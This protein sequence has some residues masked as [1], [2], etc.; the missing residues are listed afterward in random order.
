MALI[1]F[2]CACA[3]VAS[4][5][6]RACSA[7][8]SVCFV[9]ASV[10]TRVRGRSLCC[11]AGPRLLRIVQRLLCGSVG[12]DEGS[13]PLLRRLRGRQL[14]LGLGKFSLGHAHGEL[15][16]RGGDPADRPSLIEG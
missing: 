15:E 11:G 5:P 2:A 10:V 13:L 12:C 4:A 6:A 9:V 1:K 7:L 8:S 3:T 14:R 16:G